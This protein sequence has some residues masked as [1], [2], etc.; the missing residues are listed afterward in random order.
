MVTLKMFQRGDG[1][2]QIGTRGL[3]ER[4]PTADE[5]IDRLIQYF[6]MRGVIPSH[7]VDAIRALLTQP[8]FE[9]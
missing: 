4:A 7:E 1:S 5:K 6:E 9:E 3:R 2:V 8:V